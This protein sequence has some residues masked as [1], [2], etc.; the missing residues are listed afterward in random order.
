MIPRLPA[1]AR[2]VLSFSFACLVALTALPAQ[3][4]LPRE[5]EALSKL[6]AGQDAAAAATLLALA[7]DIANQ[8]DDAVSAARVEA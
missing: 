3:E 7:N 6:A 1:L 4:L 8:T 5:L 2:R